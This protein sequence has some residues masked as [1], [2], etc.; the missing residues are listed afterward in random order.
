M[1]EK[2]DVSIVASDVNF[3]SMNMKELRTYLRDRNQKVTGVK[4][5]LIARAKGAHAL[6]LQKNTSVVGQSNASGT[7]GISLSI[8]S[9][10]CTP[11]G[12][13]MPDPLSLITGW[14]DDLELLPLF[15]ERDIYNYLVLSTHRTVDSKPMKAIRQLKAA[16]FYED[17]HVHSI[18][19]HGISDDCDHLF[20][21]CLVI[22]SL[23][24][25]DKKSN[26]DH[27]VWV[28]LSKVTGHINSAYCTCAA[29]AGEACNH[30]SA[31]LYALVDI[32][33]KKEAGQ[34]SCTSTKCKWMIPRDRKLAPLTAD[35]LHLMSSGR[36]SV[37]KRRR[38]ET[39]C[40]VTSSY[41]DEPCDMCPNTGMPKTS[42]NVDR[43]RKK[44][45]SNENKKKC[46]FVVTTGV[47]NDE[48]QMDDVRLPQLHAPPVDFCFCD[49][50]DL[51][52]QSCQNVF[53]NYA[54]TIKV[55]EEESTIIESITRGQ[56]KQENWKEARKERIT[57]SDFGS[58]CLRRSTTEPDRLVHHVLGYGKDFSSVHTRWGTSHEPAARQLYVLRMTKDHPNVRVTQCG[59]IVNPQY[60]YLG[61]SPDGLVSCVDCEK[62]CSSYG[63]L[64]IKCPSTLRDLKP[65]EAASQ[66]D[67][68]CK[69][70]E[71]M[72]L[73]L[74]ENHPYYFQV[75]GQMAIAQRE[76]CDFVVWTLK[77]ISIQR[78][79]FDKLKWEE[80]FQKLKRFYVTAIVPE[81]FSRRVHRGLKLY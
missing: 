61:A 76:W 74:K 59:L 46:G 60:P 10:L 49:S 75:Q 26:P 5:Q 1:A 25:T 51:S 20:V 50:V 81:L 44:L 34:L 3:D 14:S 80:M 12:Y 17:R 48:G 23:P 69:L 9:K 63:L 55:T 37:L 4:D 28:C 11:S 43:F 6:K 78:I 7:L 15:T 19:V 64:E 73:K 32:S 68:F 18:A 27:H 13:Q 30:V 67:F 77:G 41:I 71:N 79:A 38:E 65:Q 35:D 29:G 70:D 45:I 22:P 72:N 33:Q 54:E 66:T 36:R 62:C 57:S 47:V 16:I 39:N 40:T 2:S 42:I 58:V 56:Q 52:S 53:E 21:R 24:T 8:T 31:L